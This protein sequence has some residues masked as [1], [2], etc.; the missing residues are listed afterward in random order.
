[1]SSGAATKVGHGL[2]KVLGIKMQYRNPTGQ[3]DLSRGES[4]FSA[5]TADTFVEQEPTTREWLGEVLPTPRTFVNWAYH[6][7]P[8]TH[9]ID[10]YNVQ[11]L[12]GDLIAGQS[13]LSVPLVELSIDD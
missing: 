3:S 13:R 2:A 1:M 4:V 5:S 10:R 8:F 11:W 12:I 7:F 9:W 6:L